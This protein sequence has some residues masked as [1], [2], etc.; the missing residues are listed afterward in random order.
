[1]ADV[2]HALPC[3][4]KSVYGLVEAK[5]YDEFQR[6]SVS[7]NIMSPILNPTTLQH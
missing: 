5:F 6:I 1:M 7:D 3:Y 2:K 4:Q